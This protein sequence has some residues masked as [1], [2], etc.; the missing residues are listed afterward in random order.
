MTRSYF[1]PRLF[2]RVTFPQLFTT[3]FTDFDSCMA[4][5]RFQRI[6]QDLLAP[7]DELPEFQEAL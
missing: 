5:L 2:R 6:I 1:P 3:Q 4:R 7:I